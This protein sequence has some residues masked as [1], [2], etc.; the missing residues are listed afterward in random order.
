MEWLSMTLIPLYT[1][2]N[3]KE[4]T[5]KQRDLLNPTDKTED[6]MFL[7]CKTADWVLAS[8]SKQ[9]NHDFIRTKMAAIHQVYCLGNLEDLNLQMC[10]EATLALLET[11]ESNVRKTV[12][13]FYS[14]IRQHSPCYET[15]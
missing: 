14:S 12:H 6:F 10:Q 4:L 2:S 13:N 9:V 5:Q 11:S 8:D 7:M 1:T 3:T 15:N